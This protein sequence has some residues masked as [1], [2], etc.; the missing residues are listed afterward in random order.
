[1]DWRAFGIRFSQDNFYQFLWLSVFTGNDF[2]LSV[3]FTSFWF[4]RL[5]VGSLALSIIQ[6]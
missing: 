1:M 3:P 6:Y 2:L 5:F 4:C